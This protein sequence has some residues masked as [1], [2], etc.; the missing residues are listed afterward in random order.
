M[1][2]W[3]IAA[4]VAGGVFTAR[5][6]YFAGVRA[7]QW[8]AM[9]RGAFLPDFART[10]RT[11]DKVQPALL[12][13]TIASLWMRSRSADGAAAALALAASAGFA[14]TMAASVALLV[15]LQRRMIREGA[16]PAVPIPALR[17]RW[18]KG[19]IGRTVLSVVSFALLLSATLVAG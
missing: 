3:E 17:S 19:H 6:L 4:V 1:D 16:D 5:V 8:L 12:V 9:E 2:G 7:P 10:I 15:P 13:V 18:V 11:A 14:L